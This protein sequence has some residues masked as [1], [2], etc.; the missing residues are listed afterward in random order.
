MKMDFA[1]ELNQSRAAIERD[2][3]TRKMDEAIRETEMIVILEGMSK[4]SG[5][6]LVYPMQYPLPGKFSYPLTASFN[7]PLP[8]T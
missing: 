3:N 1:Y 5:R 8:G 2:E 6:P 7:Y 4:Q